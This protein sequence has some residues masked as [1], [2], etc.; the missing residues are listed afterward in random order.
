ME[1]KGIVEVCVSKGAA[2]I[3]GVCGAQLDAS[4]AYRD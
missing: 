1:S 4:V 2:G 3:G